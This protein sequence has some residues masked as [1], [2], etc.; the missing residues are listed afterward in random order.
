MM[1]TNP[2]ERAQTQKSRNVVETDDVE[3]LFYS[4]GACSYKCRVDFC[5]CFVHKKTGGSNKK[6]KNKC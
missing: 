3:A 4:V 5:Q 1:T 2:L 6:Q